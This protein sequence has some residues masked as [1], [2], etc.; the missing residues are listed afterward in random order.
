MD[1]KDNNGRLGRQQEEENSEMMSVQERRRRREELD[2]RETASDGRPRSGD[3]FDA[4]SSDTH[5]Y[6][7]GDMDMS[8][9]ADIPHGAS[10]H[11]A[12]DSKNLPKSTPGWRILIQELVADKLAL[13]S[14]IIFVLITSY[15]FGLTMFLDR[16]TIVAVDLFAINEPPNED[17]RL[18]TDYGGRD[19]FGQ[20]IIGTRNSLAIG[21]LVT[22]M[23]VGFGIAYG[24]V[25]GYFGGQI[26]NMMMRVVDFFMVLPF[27]MVIIVF[28]TISP[29]YN[30]FTFSLIMAAFLWTGT[31]RLVRSLAIQEK[32]LD[33]INASKTLGSSHLKIVFTQMMPNL[34]GIIIVNS[35]LSLAA[36]IGIE[37]GLSFIGFGF[38]EDYPSLGTLMAYATN[39]QTLQ[40]RWW[41]WVP[42]A[43]LILLMMLCVRNIGE[44]LRRAG[45]AR[46]RQ[47]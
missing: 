38:P 22:I 2:D 19:I 40:H 33:Y 39:S 25:S 8:V 14:L 6:E 10:G 47:A 17:F 21:I 12:L 35:T 15:V 23:S 43:V 32:E 4:R 20:L 34:I 13:F 5:R 46:Q 44:A 3:P 41:I 31:A 29:S 37:S 11:G 1:N 30:I 26:D 27:L 28:V 42:A 45:D 18:G 9:K 24:V 7:K 36:N 16:Q